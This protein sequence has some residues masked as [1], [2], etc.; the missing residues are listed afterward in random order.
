MTP[1]T[2]IVTNPASPQQRAALEARAFALSRGC[3]VERRNPP[4]CPLFGLRPMSA[5]DR[6][7]WIH[8]LSDAELEYLQVYHAT[9]AEEKTTI[10]RAGCARMRV[11]NAR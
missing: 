1:R 4:D 3:P 6:R 10:A 11:G 8:K 2:K 7:A 5:R 9:C